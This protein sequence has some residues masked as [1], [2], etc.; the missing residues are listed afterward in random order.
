[1]MKTI[2]RGAWNDRLRGKLNAFDP[3]YLIRLIPAEGSFYFSH[4]PF[5]RV[6][7]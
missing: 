2:E 1:M 7:L 3:Y 6:F 5:E 4:P